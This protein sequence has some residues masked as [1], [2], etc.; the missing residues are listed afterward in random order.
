MKIIALDGASGTGKS[1]L[2]GQL[3]AY[4]RNTP[5]IRNDQVRIE[6][7]LDS[8]LEKRL[9]DLKKT[10]SMEEQ[11]PEYCETLV[12]AYR[13]GCARLHRED[14]IFQ[15]ENDGCELI[16]ILDRYLFSLYAI[17]GLQWGIRGLYD[18][19]RDIQKPE[20]QFL[21][22]LASRMRPEDQIFQVATEEWRRHGYRPARTIQNTLSYNDQKLDPAGYLE[23]RSAILD[24][25]H[26][27]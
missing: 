18:Q 15:R 17:Q 10:S 8:E 23:V 5:G 25:L 11:R 14:A 21:I 2:I 3:N 1:V 19:C 9:D 6:R 20:L 22:R 26:T 16:F 24:Y 7:L 12:R 4:F 27:L 13:D